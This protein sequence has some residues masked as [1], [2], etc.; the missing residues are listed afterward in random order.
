MTNLHAANELRDEQLGAVAGG[1]PTT[2]RN[3]GGCTPGQQ[4]TA[5]Y[6]DVINH[7]VAQ[8]RTIVEAL[9]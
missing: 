7:I 5:G 1:H 4:E 9:R 6:L 8:T 2:I 3:S